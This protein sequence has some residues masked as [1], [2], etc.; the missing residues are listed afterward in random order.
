MA[1]RMLHK[2]LYVMNYNR[3]EIQNVYWQWSI[4][5]PHRALLQK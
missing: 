1:S 2:G 4:A 3:D 5:L